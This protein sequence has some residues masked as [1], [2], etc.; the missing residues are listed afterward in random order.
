MFNGC[1]NLVSLDLSNF[2]TSLVTNMDSM[3]KG[4]KALKFLDI[5][6]FD[7][8][9]VTSADNIIDDLE[10]LKY[11]N[12]YHVE[13]SGEYLNINNLNIEDLKVCQKEKIFSMK[14]ENGETGASKEIPIIEKCCYYDLK[15]DDCE[16]ETT[17]FI[18]I[19]YGTNTEY[20]DGT[21][22]AKDFRKGIEFIIINNDHSSKKNDTE[23]LYIKAGNKV[24]IYF[25]EVTKLQNFFY[26]TKDPN[27]KNIISIDLSHLNASLVTSFDL[28]FYGC[29]SLVSID[30]T[31]FNTS[32]S[33]N[34]QQMFFG[35]NSLKYIDLSSFNTSSVVNMNGMFYNCSKLQYLDLSNFD[36]SKVTTLRS[37][38]G[39]CKSLKVLDIS[40]F[41]MT[42]VE[43]YDKMFEGV[44]LRY[45]NL[46]NAKDFKVDD[47]LNKMD[48]LIVCKQEAILN[49]EKI[50]RKCCYFDISTDECISSNYILITYGKNTIYENGFGYNTVGSGWG[51]PEDF[52]GK[53]DSYFIINR[54]YNKKLNKESKLYIIAGKQLGI[55]FLSNFMTM[56]RYFDSSYDPNVKNITSIDLSH[57][58]STN[59][60]NM[61]CLFRGCELLQSINTIN[62]AE[63]SIYFD[64]SLVEN[65]DSMFEG[66]SSL[67]SVDLSGF[68]TSLVTNMNSFFMKCSKLKILD[69]SH[70][71]TSKVEKM[72]NMFFGC[73]LLKYLDIST[74]NFQSVSEHVSL[75]AETSDLSYINIYDIKD[76]N[77][78]AFSAILSEDNEWQNLTVCQKENMITQGVI[79]SECC[80]FNVTSEKCESSNY[81]T[82][83][84]GDNANYDNGF[85]F[86]EK[87]EEFRKDIDFIINGNHEKK[88]K[89]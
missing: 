67:E 70:F 73:K 13:N 9:S 36:T 76:N 55:Y 34:M 84:F 19:Y 72:N 82:I 63:D 3:F 77:A 61:K 59:V 11:I 28:M 23:N 53:S 30:L 68:N 20:S 39:L 83:Y 43:K 86:N 79:N 56:E 47:Q 49:N 8:K 52:R 2:N 66:C 1:T 45:L 21:G 64:T 50:T 54:D 74:L 7:M 31:N 10:N 22:F 80:Y 12:I 16:P 57:F 78:K 81:I 29:D 75:F 46:Y 58:N 60:N 42:K 51:G 14:K 89:R 85:A 38:F 87:G 62:T 24:E 65:M 4:C 33:K 17:N 27:V 18:V 69:L 26:Y 25:S 32:S 41:D 40:S 44:N 6:S 35:C 71:D 5:Y 48:N 37:M 88:K 15:S